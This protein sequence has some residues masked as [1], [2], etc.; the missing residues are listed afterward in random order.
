MNVS[1]AGGDAGP[2]LLTSKKKWFCSSAH[3]ASASTMLST[4]LP[5]VVYLLYSSPHTPRVVPFL[6]TKE[7]PRTASLSVTLPLLPHAPHPQLIKGLQLC[8]NDTDEVSSFNPVLP[9]SENVSLLRSQG[10]V[11]DHL[12]SA[13]SRPLLAEIKTDQFRGNVCSFCEGER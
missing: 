11:P 12:L 3:E 7:I 5:F 6:S 8:R 4:M 1:L 10:L 2:D 13:D 9:L